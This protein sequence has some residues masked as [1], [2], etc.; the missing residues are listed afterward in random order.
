MP[1]QLLLI[2]TAAGFGASPLLI[3]IAVQH[4]PP[5]TLGALRSA[6][7]LPLLMIAAGALWV[8]RPYAWSD[9][10][11][12]AV[13]GVLV[14]A[15]PFVTMAAGMQYIPSGLGG[16]LYASMPLMVLALSVVFLKDEPVTKVQILRI[17][18]GLVGVVLI[19]GPALV[20]GGLAQVGLGAAF[21]LLSPLSYAAGNVWFRRREPLPPL[22]L[23]AGMFAV[24]AV[25]MWPLALVLD[26]RVAVAPTSAVLGGLAALVVLATVAPALLNYML[27]RKAG[28]NRAALAMFLMPGFSVVFGWVFLA[29]RLPWLSFAG[30]ALVI[31]ASVPGVLDRFVARPLSLRPPA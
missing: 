14:I 8:A 13:G 1:V 12:A 21:T 6:L 26:G 31:A 29:E 7:G 11:T 20:A 28:A 17:A 15:I 24:G 25:L 23:N 27:V 4:F 19:A 5:F 10:F 9:L 30:L 16:M 3:Q 18:V 2:L 22:V